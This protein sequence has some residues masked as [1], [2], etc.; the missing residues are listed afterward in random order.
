M[1]VVKAF[2]Q[3]LI[4]LFTNLSEHFS[5][6]KST[7]ETSF[8]EEIVWKVSQIIEHGLWKNLF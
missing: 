8:F 3:S 7:E 2:F 5:K 1:Y 6:K 4:H